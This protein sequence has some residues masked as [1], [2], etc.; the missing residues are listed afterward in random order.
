MIYPFLFACLLYFFFCDRMTLQAMGL[1]RIIYPYFRENPFKKY[2]TRCTK[3]MDITIQDTIRKIVT[4]NPIVLFMKGIP[5]RPLCGFSADAVKTLQDS[6]VGFFYVNVLSDEAI[7]QGI[8]DYS[9]WPT[10]PQLYIDGEFIGGADIIKTLYESGELKALL[11]EV[12][13]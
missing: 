7:R 12:A 5:D 11:S 8:K 13:Q 9:N 6:G 2:Q 10:I 1:N 4:E 3:T